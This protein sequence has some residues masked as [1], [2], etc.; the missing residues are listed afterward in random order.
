MSSVS[1]EFPDVCDA[2]TTAAVDG[3]TASGM[4]VVAEDGRTDDFSSHFVR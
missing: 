4:C 3:R 1:Q 2:V